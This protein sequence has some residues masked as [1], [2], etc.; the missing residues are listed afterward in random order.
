MHQSHVL[1]GQATTGVAQAAAVVAAAS[2]PTSIPRRNVIYSFNELMSL[3]VLRTTGSA[4][5]LRP[6]PP[7]LDPTNAASSHGQNARA[8]IAVLHSQATTATVA[9]DSTKDSENVAVPASPRQLTVEQ[10][11]TTVDEDSDSDKSTSHQ[12]NQ[13]LLRASTRWRTSQILPT[14]QSQRLRVTSPPQSM[15]ATDP[16]KRT[17]QEPS[18]TFYGSPQPKRPKAHPPAPERKRRKEM[19]ARKP[20]QKRYN[21]K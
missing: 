9:Q 14:S 16:K 1:S 19:K 3:G 4:Q 5:P 18:A 11:P 21:D 8:A 2:L 12:D 7:L 6:A 17:G 20:V 15:T 10:L 13:A